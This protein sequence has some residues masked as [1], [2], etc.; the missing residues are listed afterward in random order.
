MKALVLSHAHPAF[1]IGGAQVAAYNLF[2]GLKGQRGW[3]AHFMAGV[4]PPVARHAA[5]PLM[6][7]GQGP[8]ETLF[9]SEDYDWFHLGLNDL[10]GIMKHFEA[11]LADLRP[12]VVNF[13][14]VM[15]FGVQAIR[16]PPRAG[17]RADRLHAARVPAD[18]RPPRP[19]DQG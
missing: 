3:D 18:L 8:D 15:G 6:S 10:D 4:G 7:L 11:F 13:H 9:W 2:N 19:D 16:R 17:R 12:D 14:H 5:T 1:S